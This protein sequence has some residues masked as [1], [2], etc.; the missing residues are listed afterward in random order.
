M[1]N[2]GFPQNSQKIDSIK[3]VLSL[4]PVSIAR[5]ELMLDMSSTLLETHAFEQA[6]PY[7]DTVL[8]ESGKLNYQAGLAKYYNNKG[9]LL[10]KEGNFKEALTAY[11]LSLDK[12]IILGDSLH[13]ANV[14]INLGE[15]Y[16]WQQNLDTAALFLNRA[17]RIFIELREIPGQINVYN[18]LG[19]IYR[20]R[21]DYP[22]AI[23]QYETAISLAEKTG[24]IV[25]V[26]RN[27]LS[28][29]I[30]Y[31]LQGDNAKALEVFMEAL[32]YY[33]ETANLEI[34][35]PLDNCIGG[36]FL[37]QEEYDE[38]L[39][40]LNSA[41]EA[42]RTLGLEMDAA[43][44]LT[45]IGQVYKELGQTQNAL[46]YQFQALEVVSEYGS[47]KDVCAVY[48]EL[49]H[50]YAIARDPAKAMEYYRKALYIADETKN[51]ENK[52]AIL[53]SMAKI[54][55]EHS[56]K[57]T[58]LKSND[59]YDTARNYLFESLKIATAMQQNN[60]I[61]DIYRLLYQADSA[62]GD[63]GAALANFKFYS[64]YKDSLNDS[65]YNERLARL[66]YEFLRQQKEKEISDL[67]LENEIKSLQVKN[68]QSALLT[69]SLE[70]EKNNALIRLLNDS[71]ELQKLK[72]EKTEKDLEN[73]NSAILIKEAELSSAKQIKELQDR[74]IRKQKMQRNGILF[75]SGLLLLT[76]ILII[77]GIQLRRK[78]EKQQAI[79]LERER[80][81][82]D[83]HDDIGSGLSKIILML[84]VLH[85][86]ARL[87]EIKD[88]TRAISKESLELS[89]NM[90]SVIWALNSRYDSLDSLIAFIRKYANDYFENSPV[91]F[92]MN[93]PAHFPPVRLSSEQRRNIYYAVK[94]ALHNIVKHA[95]ATL[96][97]IWVTYTGE[98]LS[99]KVMDNGCGMPV[100]KNERNGFG[101]GIIQMRK[102]IET[103]GGQF[104]MENGDGTTLTFT[105]P[106]GKNRPL[107][108]YPHAQS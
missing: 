19:L 38:A 23:N 26:N 58:P 50:T 72:L 42:S 17:M 88:K 84:E 60:Y 36:I 37:D 98:V 106:V 76:G 8:M 46:H 102:R 29:G 16:T 103:M 11:T 89:K 86:E 57:T 39:K 25:L 66:Q 85:K 33:R 14:C 4:Q 56:A 5:I 108:V 94:E 31:K 7:L 2:P 61:M 15:H 79:S 68:Q 69:S 99:L 101:N 100:N 47:K 21:G 44:N 41:L 87:A 6:K 95:N 55:I 45:R 18:R 48:I 52:S 93:A 105:M 92:K 91:G 74:E 97:E 90:S 28:L 82:G 62:S 35:T 43:A 107:G 59:I 83:L 67:T 40:H 20:F 9:I 53:L 80:I 96:A 12:G 51:N 32:P 104:Y 34:L 75:T 77:R 81:S 71:E 22:E 3:S 78:L 27:K 65:E 54:M 30:I 64:A 10:Q 63:L 49:G 13:A 70:A 1:I 73:K 24:N